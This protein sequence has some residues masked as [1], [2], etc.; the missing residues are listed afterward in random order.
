MKNSSPY[1]T[2]DDL[3]KLLG[4]DTPQKVLED[5]M[6]FN[7]YDHVFSLELEEAKRRGLTDEAAEEFAQ[8]ASDEYESNEVDQY[9]IRYEKVIC[10]VSKELFGHHRLLLILDLKTP[11]RWKITPSL[12]NRHNRPDWHA[13]AKEIISTINGVGYFGFNS[14]KELID[15][16]PYGS[17]RGAVLN[18]LGWISSYP[19]VYE[20]HK[21][22]RMVEMRM[23]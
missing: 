9:L 18:H 22:K 3:C 2:I 21:A 8:N 14:V 23:R 12:L 1:L 7:H 13:A 17:V 20:G 6:S 11:G 4:V 5:M 15:S 10:D 19:E 16:G